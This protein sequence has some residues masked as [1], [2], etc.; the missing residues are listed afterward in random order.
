ADTWAAAIRRKTSTPRSIFTPPSTPSCVRSNPGRIGAGATWIRTSFNSYHKPE[1]LPHQNCPAPSNSALG[2]RY[3]AAATSSHGGGG[4]P[5]HGL[6]PVSCSCRRTRGS[7]RGIPPD[8]H[9]ESG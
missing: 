3:G 7:H 4:D 2:G 9:P 6:R 8:L 1:K 5:G